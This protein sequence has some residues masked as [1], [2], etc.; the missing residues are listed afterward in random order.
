[1]GLDKF[2][3]CTKHLLNFEIE[4]TQ[5]ATE[6]NIHSLEILRV[7]LYFLRCSYTK[8]VSKAKPTGKYKLHDRYKKD[9]SAYKTCLGSINTEIQAISNPYNEER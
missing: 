9:L 6:S 7:E 4:Y 2:V 8:E 1:M 3:N 5:S